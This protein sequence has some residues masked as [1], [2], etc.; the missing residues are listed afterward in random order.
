METGPNARLKKVAQA[1][2]WPKGIDWTRYLALLGADELITVSTWSRT[3]DDTALTLSS[4][5]IVTGARKTQ[6]RMAGG[7][8]GA[9]YVVTNRITTSSGVEDERSFTIVV[10]DR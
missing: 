6:V 2:N 4:S 1:S 9:S 5:S 10:G 3:G 7:T 8:V